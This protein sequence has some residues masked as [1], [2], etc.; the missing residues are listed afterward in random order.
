VLNGTES[1]IIQFI[2]DACGRSRLREY[3]ERAEKALVGDLQ[4]GRITALGRLQTSFD[5]RRPVSICHAKIPSIEILGEV[6][7]PKWPWAPSWLLARFGSGS[8][9]DRIWCDVRIPVKRLK[10]LYPEPLIK[11]NGVTP[12]AGGLG[13]R[14]EGSDS[15]PEAWSGHRPVVADRK[16]KKLTAER[17]PACGDERAAPDVTKPREERQV[18]RGR[19]PKYDWSPIL[20]GLRKLLEENGYPEPGSGDQAQLEA[21]TAEQF[22]PDSQPSE[23][24][25]RQ[26]VS[27]AIKAFQQDI[28]V[29][30]DK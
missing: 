21:W 25:I 3:L 6:I 1:D 24:L 27:E 2:N 4:M 15:D 22:D 26:K 11:V 7:L 20:T 19:R 13:R 23:S 9:A 12:G 16:G 30:A 29:K 18:C 17:P 28:G 5:I 10:R 8:G 14:P